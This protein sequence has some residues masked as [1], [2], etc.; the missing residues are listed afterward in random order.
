MSL[1]ASPQ[2]GVA[3]RFPK[4]FPSGE[5]GSRVPRKRETDE[6]YL[7][8]PMGE[9]PPE[10]GGEGGEGEFHPLSHFVTAPPEWEPRGS[11][12]GAKGGRRK[13]I[14]TPVCGLVR[15]D[16]SYFGAYQEKNGL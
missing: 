10:G 11:Q 8:L 4:A 1:R 3:I 14:A 7:P 13:R 2:T 5:G 9:V 16:N 6:G 12:G 15:N